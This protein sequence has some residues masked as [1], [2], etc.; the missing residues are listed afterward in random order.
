MHHPLPQVVLTPDA[1]NRARGGAPEDSPV[2]VG[3]AELFRS[4]RADEVPGHARLHSRFCPVLIVDRWLL[5]SCGNQER[6]GKA[7]L[8]RSAR[9][10][11]YF[12]RRTRASAFRWTARSFTLAFLPG[13]QSRRRTRASAFR[14]TA[15]SFTL[16]F[17]PGSHTGVSALLCSGFGLLFALAISRFDRWR[18][19]WGFRSSGPCRRGRVRRR[20]GCSGIRESSGRCF[21]RR[22]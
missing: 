14:W 3:K 19:W 20:R 11:C 15:R 10:A 2:A 18:R 16:A 17:L 22:G 13:S 12:G 9:D 8:F 21:R 5:R 7:E 6:F 1:R 4:A